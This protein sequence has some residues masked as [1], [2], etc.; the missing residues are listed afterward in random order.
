VQSRFNL[1]R[2]LR[3]AYDKFRWGLRV[4]GP[5]AALPGAIRYGMLRLRRPAT[6]EVRLRSGPVLEFDYPSQ[7]PPTLMMFGD[8]IDP[9]FAFL[10]QVAE[11]GWQ[12][13][14]VGAAIG[15]FSMFAARCLPDA[16][17]HAFEPEASNIGTLKRNIA[18]NGAQGRVVVHQSA[19]SDRQ[20]TARFETSASTWNSHL[21]DASAD[22]PGY[23]TVP[24]ET[25]TAVLPQLGLDH[26]DILKINVAGLEAS[27]LAGA[28]PCL[29]EGKVDM[30]IL[31]LGL[32][33]LPVYGDIARLGYRFF[34]YHPREHALYEVTSFDHDAVLAHR[35]WPARHIIGIRDQVLPEL[36]DG[37]VTI[38]PIAY[39]DKISAAPSHLSGAQLSGH[40]S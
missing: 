28:M 33:S 21:V 39:R 14:D 31:L 15:Q 36:L 38:R 13:I 17:I 25:L 11:P 22:G 32:P 9:E 5:G 37:K 2:R 24:V 23:E 8:F 27:V 12:V 6:G 1:S 3:Q 10:Q 18:R 20:G 40:E 30:L 34:Y 19:L 26:V 16:V 4:A 35:P 29:A 7:F